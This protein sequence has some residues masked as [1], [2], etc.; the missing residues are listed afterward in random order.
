M[1][2]SHI[3]I[4][5]TIWSKKVKEKAGYKCEV[6]LEEG[7]YLN[8][9]HIIGRRYRAT[10]WGAEIDGKYDLCGFSG[11][12][13]CHREYDEHSPKEDFIRRVVIGE[14]RYQKIS[15]KAKQSVAKNQDFETI[16]KE[17]EN[18]R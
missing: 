11:C 5:D 4:L 18:A 6:C 13:G 3:K 1:L 15:E 16:K 2:K 9:C 10:R 7:V 8:S 12:F 14:E 17:L